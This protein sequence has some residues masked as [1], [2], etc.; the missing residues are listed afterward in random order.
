MLWLIQSFLCSVRFVDGK[1]LRFQEESQDVTCMS[2]V[3]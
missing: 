1:D 2:K 3:L